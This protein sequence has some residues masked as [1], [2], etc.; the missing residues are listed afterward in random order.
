MFELTSEN[1]IIFKA[2]NF[3][4]YG[5]TCNITSNGVLV[6]YSGMVLVLTSSDISDDNQFLNN[7]Q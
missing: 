3:F 6:G 4:L 2:L 5:N 7:I 1:K